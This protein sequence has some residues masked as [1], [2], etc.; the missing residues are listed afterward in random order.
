M[1]RTVAV[2]AE[3]ALAGVA[4]LGVTAFTHTSWFRANFPAYC[5]QARRV[6]LWNVWPDRWGAEGEA[7]WSGPTRMVVAA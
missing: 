5:C 6:L 4:A 1:R 3:G 7:R 2:A